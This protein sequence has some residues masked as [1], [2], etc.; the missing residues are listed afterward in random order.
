MSWRLRTGNHLT[1]A[2]PVPPLSLLLAFSTLIPT[3]WNGLL[4]W[5]SRYS[6]YFNTFGKVETHHS[7]QD[8]VSLVLWSRRLETHCSGR[9]I[10]GKNPYGSGDLAC[11]SLKTTCAQVPVWK[12][13]VSPRVSWL[14][15]GS[16]NLVKSKNLQKENNVKVY[17]KWI[18]ALP[19]LLLLKASS[20]PMGP[21]DLGN[22]WLLQVY[23][24]ISFPLA[25]KD[26][27]L[28]LTP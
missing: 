14:E 26:T 10:W 17:F 5:H 6:W 21:S 9:S 2:G 22:N 27:F 12:L 15:G 3:L 4:D 18:F 13:W 25:T 28:G 11:D 7:K 1:S 8:N 19:A 16:C 23:G 20:A 24:F